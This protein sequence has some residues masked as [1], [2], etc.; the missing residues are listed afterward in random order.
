MHLSFIYFFS[1]EMMYAA[2]IRFRIPG[3]V[4][5]KYLQH[6]HKYSSNLIFSARKME[7]SGKKKELKHELIVCKSSVVLKAKYFS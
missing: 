3:T 7:I 1:Q 4:S 5:K 2:N 6:M